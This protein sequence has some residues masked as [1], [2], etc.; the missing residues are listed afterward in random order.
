MLVSKD[1]LVE[2]ICKKHSIELDKNDPIINL[3]L[4]NDVILDL[5]I[6]KIDQKLNLQSE[7][8]NEITN[9]YSQEAK[10]LAEKIVGTALDNNS[11]EIKKGLAQI[12]QTLNRYLAFLWLVLGG[13]L[14][15]LA[16][17]MQTA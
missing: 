1:E 13:I 14:Y 15:V 2:R 16:L 10:G 12:Q 17:V 4:I 11:P 7:R 8:M 3:A 5:Y 9:K 6:E